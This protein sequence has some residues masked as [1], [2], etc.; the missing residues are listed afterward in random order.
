MSV[1]LNYVELNWN[2]IEIQRTT[3]LESS[4]TYTNTMLNQCVYT[5]CWFGKLTGKLYVG[6]FKLCWLVG[7]F[8]TLIGFKQKQDSE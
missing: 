7:K 5:V 4:C 2:W 8:C 3:F 6:W 1:S